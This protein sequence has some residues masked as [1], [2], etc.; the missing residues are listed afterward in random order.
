MTGEWER[1]RYGSAARGKDKEERGRR[2]SWFEAGRPLYINSVIGLVGL[3]YERTL[4]HLT[5]ASG[6]FDLP[7]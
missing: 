1:E 7:I 6:G 2:V 4:H 3:L 5:L